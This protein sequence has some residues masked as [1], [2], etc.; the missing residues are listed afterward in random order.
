M[1]EIVAVGPESFYATNDHYSKSAHMKFLEGFLGLQLTNVVYYSPGNV[2][3]VASGLYSANG[4]AI[5]NDKKYVIS[6]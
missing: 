6:Y 3:E 5:S 4:I 2:R 1:N